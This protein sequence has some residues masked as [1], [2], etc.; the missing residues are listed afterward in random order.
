M[1]QIE[2]PKPEINGSLVLCGYPWV[3]N[4]TVRENILFGCSYDEEKYDTIV[5]ACSLTKDFSLLSGGDLTEVGERGITLSGGQK[6]RISLARAVYSDTDIILMD[7]VLSA[8]DAKVGKHIVDHCL[9]DYL[10][11]KTR[12]LATHQLSLIGEADK[13]VFLNGD[14]TVDVGSFHE[15]NMYNAGFKS[16]MAHS[17]KS[18][19][20]THSE[21][22]DDS[23]ESGDLDYRR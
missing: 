5:E 15:L 18:A 3:Q 6:A 4:A 21:K 22:K 8:V 1:K 16:L 17:Q 13:V 20:D 2:G 9:L 7:D 23:D 19:Q 12:I 11:D 14:G 10:K